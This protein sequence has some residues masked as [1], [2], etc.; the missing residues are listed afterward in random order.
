MFG[1]EFETTASTKLPFIGWCRSGG[2][3]GEE[4]GHPGGIPL[5]QSALRLGELQ[6][7]SVGGHSPLRAPARASV[8]GFP[9]WA[10]HGALF[11]CFHPLLNHSF[12]DMHTIWGKGF[13]QHICSNNFQPCN[14]DYTTYGYRICD[15]AIFH[16]YWLCLCLSAAA[17]PLGVLPF[18]S[19]M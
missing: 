11:M 3:G 18:S 1:S 12:W 15:W 5:R 4:T 14:G 6:G 16:I 19:T 13:L 7:V 8:I 17:V 10:S 9:K 2:G